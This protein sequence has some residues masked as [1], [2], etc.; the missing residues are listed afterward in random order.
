[1]YHMALCESPGQRLLNSPW[2]EGAAPRTRH[3]PAPSAALGLEDEA[4]ARTESH[5]EGCAG[6]GSTKQWVSVSALA[7]NP[8]VSVPILESGYLL[9]ARALNQ[10]LISMS[11]LFGLS[12][13]EN[14][15]QQLFKSH[16]V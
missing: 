11:H 10:L 2:S 12:R 15:G 5:H 16:H 1:M 13:A 3:R 9:D 6:S 4:G 7:L 14:Q 8:I